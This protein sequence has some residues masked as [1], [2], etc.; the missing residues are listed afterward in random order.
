MGRG[1]CLQKR[2]AIGGKAGRHLAIDLL[3]QALRG[4]KSWEI[5]HTFTVCIISDFVRRRKPPIYEVSQFIFL[6]IVF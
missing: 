5:T 4:Q 2:K 1:Q 3:H 6:G